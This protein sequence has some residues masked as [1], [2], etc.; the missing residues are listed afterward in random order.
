VMLDQLPVGF[1]ASTQAAFLQ[2]WGI[3]ELVREG[4]A[5]WENMKTA[6]D[7][8]AMKMRSRISE[9]EALCDSAGLGSFKVLE[10]FKD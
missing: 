7:L 9:S 4:N 5:Y 1:T 10:W 3:D 8:A 2:Q 6:P